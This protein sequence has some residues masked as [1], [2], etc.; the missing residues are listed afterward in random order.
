MGRRGKAVAGS[1]LDSR[2]AEGLADTMFALS[3]PSRIQILFLLLG[4]P[5]DVSDLVVAL[6]MEQSAV[7]HQLRVLRDHRL[8]SVVRDGNRRVYGIYDDH[9]AELLGQA[10]QHV[11]SRGGEKGLLS[12]VRGSRGVG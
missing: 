2:L 5:R 9:V 7:S 10:L 11:E 6:G 3:T 4:G 12:R 8:V 1:G